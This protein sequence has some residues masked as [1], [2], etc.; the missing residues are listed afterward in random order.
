MSE[1]PIIKRRR[2]KHTLS[3]EER[4]LEA[5]RNARNTASSYLMAKNELS[6]SE[7]RAKATQQRKSIFGYRRPE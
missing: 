1:K 3:L 2:V 5:S 6:F 4:L 7:R